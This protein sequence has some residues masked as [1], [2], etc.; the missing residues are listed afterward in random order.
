[1]ALLCLAVTGGC[2]TQ[3]PRIPPYSYISVRLNALLPLHPA[4]EEVRHLDALAEQTL[5]SSAPSSS[6]PVVLAEPVLPETLPVST[7]VPLSPVPTAAVLTS[8]ANRRLESL[9]DMLRVRNARAIERE[10]RVREKEME[11]V[12]AREESALIARDQQEIA[13]LRR[14]FDRDTRN[15]ELKIIAA[16][17]QIYA[18]SRLPNANELRLAAQRTLAQLQSQ[19]DERRKALEET[20][21][22]TVASREQRLGAFRQQKQME[23]AKALEGRAEELRTES[24][25][26]VAD[27]QQQIR[28]NQQSLADLQ[29]PSV[30][31]T[32]AVRAFPLA[33]PARVAAA[34]RMPPAPSGGEERARSSLLQQRA[35]LIA[36]ITQDLRRR[37]ERL[38][39]ENRWRI[40]FA[41]TPGVPDRTEDIRPLLSREWRP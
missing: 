3:E 39:A 13:R 16:E 15:L 2:R 5:P 25:R 30:P 4:W 24:E 17:T 38:A 12:V 28:A 11:A 1:M 40:S 6:A 34:Y 26:T 9:R 32:S 19:K 37:L 7:S 33:S 10:R 8:A 31:Q 36:Y 27:Y 21:K 14:H 22:K 18:Y 35:R 23:L 20:I 41:Q 29:M